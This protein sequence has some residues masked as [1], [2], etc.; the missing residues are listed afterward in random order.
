MYTP[1]TSV[2]LTACMSLISSKVNRYNYTRL[3]Y[4]QLTTVYPPVPP[5]PGL[6]WIYCMTMETASLN[7]ITLRHGYVQLVP[8]LHAIYLWGQNY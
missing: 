8:A 1:S 2:I 4:G 3:G 5:V 6:T 7:T